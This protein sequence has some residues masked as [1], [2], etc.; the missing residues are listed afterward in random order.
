MPGHRRAV[1]DDAVIAASCRS[2]GL[3]SSEF[4]LVSACLATVP[5]EGAVGVGIP[6]E[7]HVTKRI[8]VSR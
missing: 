2:M 1:G 3:L 6:R 4:G 8:H 5:R 7:V